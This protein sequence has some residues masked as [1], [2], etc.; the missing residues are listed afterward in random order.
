VDGTRWILSVL[1]EQESGKGHG[2]GMNCVTTSEL[3]AGWEGLLSEPEQN[4]QAAHLVQCTRCRDLERTMRAIVQVTPSVSVGAGLTDRDS[5]PAESELLDY[6]S[7]RLTASDR[8]KM[9]SHLARCRTCLGQ[10]AAMVSAGPEELPPVAAEWQG[11]VYEAKS[12]I[13]GYSEARRGGWSALVP[14]W[15]YG[16]ATSAVVAL[17]AVGWYWYAAPGA[18]SEATSPTAQV[19]PASP[20]AAH[21]PG[22][23]D[24]LAKQDQPTPLRQEH[25]PETQVRKATGTTA[26]SLRVLWPQEGRQIRREGLEIRWQAVPEAHRYQVSILNHKGDLVWEGEAEGTRVR[27]PDDVRLHPGERYFVWVLAHVK[28][29]GVVQSPSAAFEVRNPDSP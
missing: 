12:I 19:T 10:V 22:K 25:Q 27:V 23:E 11:A 20:P 16:L 3:L 15:R 17:L 7:Q 4:Q 18:P 2:R 13:E 1:K 29:Q 26:P 6:F 9:Q 14:I 8:A 24:L 21:Q 5:C 28:G